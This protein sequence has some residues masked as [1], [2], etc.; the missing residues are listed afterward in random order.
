MSDYVIGDIHG[1]YDSLRNLLERINYHPSRDKLWF[2]GDLVGRGPKP[3]QVLRQLQQMQTE[4]SR[5]VI[6][7]GNHDLHLIA[8]ALGAFTRPGALAKDKTLEPA[9][10][11]DAEPL[12]DWLRRQP[13]L[14]YDPKLQMVLTHAG[15]PHIWTL[16]TARHQARQVEEVLRGS[17][18]EVRSILPSLY[19][20]RPRRWSACQT[21]AE[22][23]RLTVNYLTRMRFCAADGELDLQA[24][25]L[26]PPAE[27]F[28]PWFAHPT[29]IAARQI[30]GHWAA[31]QGQTRAPNIWHLDYGCVWGKALGARRLDDGKLYLVAAV[32]NQQPRQRT[33]D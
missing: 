26:I 4:N 13:L 6:A 27:R 1:C 16:A 2:T 30:F 20:N 23:M 33:K 22:R 10:G 24:S 18:D 7:L 14:H 32:E 5:L 11:T 3:L 31:L 28:A 9:L 19:G 21:R 25:G 8:L 12:V 17:R 15:I 29:Q